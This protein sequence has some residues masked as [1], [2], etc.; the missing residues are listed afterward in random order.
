[1]TAKQALKQ[2]RRYWFD[3]I[4]ACNESRTRYNHICCCIDQRTSEGFRSTQVKKQD[5]LEIIALLKCDGFIIKDILGGDLFE[6]NWCSCTS[7][8]TNSFKFYI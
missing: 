2:T 8:T 1:M 6:I 5:D 7:L 4:Y 3:K